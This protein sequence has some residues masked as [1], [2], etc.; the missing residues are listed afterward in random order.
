MMAQASSGQASSDQS[1]RVT[2]CFHGIGVPRRELEP[3]EERFW[4]GLGQFEDILRAVHA[5]PRP[6]DITFDDSNDSDFTV[7]LPL[8]LRL[9]LSAQF[10]VI[11]GRLD[12]P[13]SL[14]R[15]EVAAMH[16]AG[17]AIGTHG[18]TH[19]SWRALAE[20]RMLDA[21]L[22]GSVQALH[23]ITRSPVTTA[24]LPQGQYD[25]RVLA[26]L[27]RHG[28]TRVYS[29]DEGSSRVSS[30]LRSRYTVIDEDSAASVSA[31]IDNPD[32]AFRERVLRAAKARIKALR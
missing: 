14:S 23:E 32:G 1:R 25:R 27:E 16:A 29:V 15:R 12:R 3:G 26:A 20:E 24:A 4:I 18:V 21:E 13:G 2:L 10:F 11:T 8:L 9:G 6:V 5:H 22:T 17:M 19:R 7:A 28:F 30:R 31:V